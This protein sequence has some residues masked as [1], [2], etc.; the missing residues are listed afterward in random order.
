MPSNSHR[1]LWLYYSHYRVPEGFFKPTR[2]FESI[3]FIFF[4]GT[5]E[6]A[7]RW[8]AELGMSR[9]LL[10]E[11][12]ES[13]RSWRACLPVLERKQCECLKSPSGDI[14]IVMIVKTSD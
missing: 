12:C 8:D 2:R 5:G 3:D 10:S 11:A 14:F 6:S 4:D 7:F 13:D 9:V 1:L